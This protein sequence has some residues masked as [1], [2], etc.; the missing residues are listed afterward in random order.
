MSHPDRYTFERPK[1]VKECKSR[2][3]ALLNG[4]RDVHMQLGDKTRRER[5]GYQKWRVKAT[6]SLAYK[7]A[8]YAFLKDVLVEMRR[9]AQA[10]KADV[11]DPNDP[12]HLLMRL[13][14]EIEK[15]EAGEEHQLPDVLDT[16]DR[17]FE[18]D[19]SYQSVEG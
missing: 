6:A 11:W 10:R 2:M 5:D 12:R 18:H 14:H 13:R 7:E 9:E 16:V 4:I 1:S 19:G 8:E 15:K 17:Y 3:R